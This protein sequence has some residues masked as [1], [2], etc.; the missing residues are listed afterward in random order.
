[1]AKAGTP[2]NL[3]RPI[4]RDAP[5]LRRG[6]L[7]KP[8]EGVSIWWM[9]DD[10][11]TFAAV[12][13]DT[14]SEYA[15]WLDYPPPGT[16]PPRHVHSRE[17]EGFFLL[18][19][20]LELKA[21]GIHTTVGDGTFF[22]APRG[23]PHEW[24]NM[25]EDNAELI[26]F[27]TPGGN[28]GFF[29]ELGAPGDE[30]PGG[31]GTMPVEEINARTPRYG[32]TYL[33]SGPDGR[34]RP[35]PIGEGRGPTLVLPGEGER[36]YAAGATYTIMV[37]GLATAG[38]YT[39]A[40]IALEPGGGMPAHRHARYEEA[41][42]VL[43]GTAAVLVDGEEYEASAGSAVLVPWGVRHRVRNHSGQTV[44]LFNL[45]VPGGI[46]EYYRAACRPS[47]GPGGDPEGDLDRLRAAGS[48]FGIEV[49]IDEVAPD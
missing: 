11:I 44:R 33:E 7:V 38:A 34:E 23:I 43:E 48:Q 39:V 45:T 26:T 21:G 28:E 13:E 17:E 6:K 18:H 25:G 40:E 37:A 29:L 10:R 5:L 31:H 12:S 49:D 19:G 41:F 47:P 42:Y 30:P 9:G 16:G 4:E 22:A 24:R 35:L 36:R 8:G 14:G 1:M 32:V 46:E 2:R 20:R 3:N 27:T 15:F